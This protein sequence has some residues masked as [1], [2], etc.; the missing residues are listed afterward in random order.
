MKLRALEPVTDR[1][2]SKKGFGFKDTNEVFEVADMVRALEL[3]ATGCLEEVKEK[4]KE[5]VAEITA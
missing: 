5:K 3:I 2:G 1:F 4:I